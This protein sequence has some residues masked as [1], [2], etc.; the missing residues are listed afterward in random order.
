MDSK[1]ND[2]LRESIPYVSRPN[3]LLMTSGVDAL[4]L[5][6]ITEILQKVRDFDNFNENNDPY[7]EHDLGAF[8][9]KGKKIFWKIDDYGGYEGYELVLTVLLASEY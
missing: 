2:A 8:D 3:L 7:G 4:G 1:T 5:E 9:Y 6:A